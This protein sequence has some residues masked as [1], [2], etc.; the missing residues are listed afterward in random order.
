MVLPGSDSVQYWQ[1][2]REKQEKNAVA[3]ILWPHLGRDSSELAVFVLCLE[4]LL[5]QGRLELLDFLLWHLSLHQVRV[6]QETSACASDSQ[7]S[8]FKEEKWWKQWKI[9]VKMAWSQIPSETHGAGEV[10][11]GRGTVLNY[12]YPPLGHMEEA[13]ESGK[14]KDIPERASRFSKELRATE[15]PF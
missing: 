6:S 8:C 4:S 14:S 11:S 13:R 9:K 12:K 5:E 15:V 10:K 2:R 7:K 3:L 1:E